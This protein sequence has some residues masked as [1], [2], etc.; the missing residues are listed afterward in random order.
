M[1]GL[2]DDPGVFRSLLEG[3]PVGVYVVDL[4]QRI[5]FWNRGAENITGHLAHEVVGQCDKGELLK[6]CDRQGRAL[7]GDHSPVATTLSHGET[8]QYSAYYL[9]KNGHRIAV[10]TRIRPILEHGGA[11]AGAIS[12]FEEAF[13][14]REEAF[15]SLM[16]GCL[17][18]TTGVPS[19]RLSRAVLNECLAGV[20]ESHSAFGLLRVRLLGLEEFRA[21]H[22]PQSIAPFL[23]A[24]AQTLRQNLDAENFLGRW[25]DDEFVAVLQSASPMMVTAAA[26]DIRCLLRQS[27]VSWWG[28]RFRIEAEVDSRVVRPGDK[29]ESLWHGAGPSERNA[30]AAGAGSE[31]ESGTGP[32]SLRG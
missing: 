11:I 4:E 20:E 14:F 5:R 23:R 12:L 22:G 13:A 9:H 26:E 17:D 15:G 8:Q 25:A 31:H 19:P 16:Y 30:K 7:S 32:G 27:E 18:A 10:R 3:L 28:D 2:L 21:K 1:S 29:M 24:T 6:P